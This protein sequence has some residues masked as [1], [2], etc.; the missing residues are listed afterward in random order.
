MHS[1]D[2]FLKTLWSTAAN[3]ILSRMFAN[4][5]FRLYGFTSPFSLLSAL[6]SSFHFFTV[7]GSGSGI[8][9]RGFA[10]YFCI[11]SRQSLLNWISNTLSMFIEWVVSCLLIAAATSSESIGIRP[12][13]LADLSLFS[14]AWLR[15][16]TETPAI[17]DAFFFVNPPQENHRAAFAIFTCWSSLGT[18]ELSVI[19]FLR[20]CSKALACSRRTRS[21][22]SFFSSVFVCF[23]AYMKLELIFKYTNKTNKQEL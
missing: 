21:A 10:A 1:K 7:F 14:I 4:G 12:F 8:N 15:A 11:I 2:A 18:G 19:R 17:S 23:G 20:A 9:A 5:A 6:Q 3:A 16:F 13:A 22:F